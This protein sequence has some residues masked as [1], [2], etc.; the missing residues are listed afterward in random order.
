M[1]R[2]RQKAEVPA[3]PAERSAAGERAFELP[4]IGKREGRPRGMVRWYDPRQLFRTG[5]EVGLSLA[6]GARTDQRVL[7]SITAEQPLFACAPDTGELWVDYVADLGDGFDPTF[8]VA[9]TIAERHLELPGEP[10]ALRRGS[11]LIMGGD[12]IYPT[13]S[14]LGYLDRLRLPYETAF[15]DGRD[16]D[17]RTIALQGERVALDLTRDAPYLLGLPGNHDWYDNLTSFGRLFCQQR[18]LGNL[19]T[20]Q[21]R[22]YFA[23]A[24]PHRWWLLAVDIQLGTDLDK[25]QVDYFRRRAIDHMQPGDR[26]I[27]IVARPDWNPQH[28]DSADL[29]NNLGYLE[30]AIAGRQ[31]KVALWLAGDLH[32]YQRYEHRP[33]GAAAGDAWHK[34][35][36]GGGGAFTHPTH[37]EPTEVTVDANETPD[38]SFT[39]QRCYPPREVS[40]RLCRRVL[41][42]PM[43]NPEFGLITGLLYAFLGWMLLDA[44]W[45]P[46]QPPDLGSAL[47]DML[48]AM[49]R[50]PAALCLALLVIGGAYLQA[51]RRPIAGPVH[52]IVHVAAA[53]LLTRTAVWG[54]DLA[55]PELWSSRVLR[56]VVP[57]VAIAVAGA[58]IGGCIVGAFLFIAVRYKRI[59]GND[60]FSAARFTSYKSFLRL[61][62]RA[63]GRLTLYPIG[64]P[65][66]PVTRL[67]SERDPERR[68]SALDKLSRRSLGPVELIE[69][70]IELSAPAYRGPAPKT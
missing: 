66:V 29:R 16:P 14:R 3:R 17:R 7:D 11:L 37:L 45:G 44:A 56:I 38:C 19:Q 32:Y 53:V 49:V 58:L 21:S 55:W 50:R 54:L 33:D 1:E 2:A 43:S 12:Q 6:L 31:A 9:R 30:E 28:E 64:I 25:P 48:A 62:F 18:G 23:L 26:V 60:A 4:R 63:D 47:A 69:D 24:L 61:R 46:G 39:E 59:L 22:S 35:T 52:G 8:A 36:C 68:R 34:I 51:A 42:F 20:V 70:P 5:P 40:R 65:R 27:V 10:E 13:P 15:F 41:L 67:E 57:L